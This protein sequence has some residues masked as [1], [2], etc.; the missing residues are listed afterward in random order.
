AQ[1]DDKQQQDGDRRMCP[2]P[3]CHR[4]LLYDFRGIDDHHFGVGEV[5]VQGLPRSVQQQVIS[6]EQ[7]NRLVTHIS[8]AALDRQ[9]HEITVRRCHAGESGFPD[10]P[11]EKWEDDFGQSR[12]AI[13]QYVRHWTWFIA[14]ANREMHVGGKPPGRLGRSAEKYEITFGDLSSLQWSGA[15]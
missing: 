12:G 9:H 10:H 2:W 4:L 8:G 14:F 1:E 11:G 5:L 7:L 13:K 3:Q 15:L 6:R